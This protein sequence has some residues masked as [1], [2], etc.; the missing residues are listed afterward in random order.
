MTPGTSCSITSALA[1]Q[2]AK[3]GGAKGFLF[4][5]EQYQGSPFCY[6]EQPHR[7][8]RTF[9]EYQAKVRE[10]GEQWMRTVNGRFAD[11][12]ILVDVRLRDH[13]SE[14]GPEGPVRSSI[15]AFSPIFSTGRSR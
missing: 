5:T 9:A 10:R 1:A 12:T 7:A 2:I 13:A 8:K 6:R 15:T 4:D 14:E 3:A 11:I